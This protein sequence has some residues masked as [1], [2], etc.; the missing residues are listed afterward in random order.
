MHAS[1]GPSAALAH[2][3][4]GSAHGLDAQPGR[5]GAARRARAGAAA[6]TPSA[7]AL[8][9]VEGPGCYGHN[10]ADDVALDAALL[11]RALPGRPV[12]VQWT[13]EDEHAW[14]PYGPAMVVDLQA[15]L[16]A[17]GAVIDWNH[18]VRSFTH[19]SP[20][21]PVRP[22]HVRRCSRRGTAQTPM[23]RPEP[24]PVLMHHAGIHRN[25][26]PLYTFPRRRV[27]KHFLGGLAAPHL[28]AARAR[29]L[30]ERVRDRVV[31]GRARASRPAS[32]RSSS[33]CGTSTT[34]ARATC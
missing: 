17:T 22:A 18:D 9:H 29:R 14:E 30:R 21:D 16:D 8:I 34:R 33:G 32:T 6:S 13:R 4:D 10:G 26:D 5:V 3:V 25:A 2:E 20:R 28:V 1:I 31:H 15:S 12:H 11:A 24:R 23:A 7:C 27:V 19:M